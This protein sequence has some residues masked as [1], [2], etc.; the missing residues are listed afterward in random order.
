MAM[1]PD[2]FQRADGGLAVFLVSTEEREEQLQMLVR[3][4]TYAKIVQDRVGALEMEGGES[5]MQA[6]FSSS[7]VPVVSSQASEE[8]VLAKVADVVTKT[9]NELQ[10]IS[11]EVEDAV[12]AD[13]K[14]ATIVNGLQKEKGTYV[15]HV[16]L[17]DAAMS[18]RRLTSNNAS[19]QQRN[20]GESEDGE[21]DEDR[22]ED[23]N[24]END[25]NNNQQNDQDGDNRDGNG[26]YSSSQDEDFI[27]MYDIQYFNVTLWT[28][29]GLL[30][31]LFYTVLL[32]INMPLMADTLLFGESAK[33]VAA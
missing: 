6:L 31:V 17:E 30:T 19:Q 8:D 25:Q 27:S 2:M 14:L 21:R 22:E 10:A 12:Q 5:L 28:A 32:M 11:I 9:G 20:L 18:R 23:R 33:M 1:V 29:L 26:Y 15:L 4:P 16:V 3:Q 13:Q 24:E 7:D